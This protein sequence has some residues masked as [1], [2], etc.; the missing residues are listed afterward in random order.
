MERIAVFCGSRTGTPPEF[1]AVAAALG[2]ELAGRGLG[3]VFGGGR[4]GLMG[5]IADAVLAAGGSIIGV[6]PDFLARRELAH[7]GVG[8]MRVVGSMHERKTVMSELADGFIALP[9]GM[10]TLD[11]IVEILTWAQLGFHHKPC[12]LLNV[13]GYY[14]PLLAF[15]DHAVAQ[16]LIRPEHRALVR[17]ADEPARLLAGFA[18]PLR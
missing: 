11:E 12:G 10:G 5:V 18:Q 7:K 16:G 2:R 14:D 6:I 9:G 13:G 3:L 8:D 4:V 15:F 1:A 17:V